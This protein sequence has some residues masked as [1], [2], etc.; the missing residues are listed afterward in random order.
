[1]SHSPFFHFFRAHHRFVVPWID[2]VWF[3]VVCEL[4][5]YVVRNSHPT[6]IGSVKK[7]SDVHSVPTY[8]HNYNK[9]L[10]ISDVVGAGWCFFPC[11]VIFCKLRYFLFVFYIFLIVIDSK[12]KH[13]VKHTIVYNF[14]D[15]RI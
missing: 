15:T 12:P 6:C 9:I 5:E 13:L 8:K 10:M 11:Y 14:K 3:Y 2:L 4:Y 1:M 7:I